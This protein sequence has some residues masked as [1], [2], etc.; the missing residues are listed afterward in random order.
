MVPNTPIENR[1]PVWKCAVCGSTEDLVEVHVCVGISGFNFDFC[2]TCEQTR[3]NECNKVL[4]DFLDKISKER[5]TRRAESGIPE[6]EIPKP[7]P[8]ENRWW[9]KFYKL[10]GW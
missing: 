10:I 5:A 7:D 1:W 8:Q 4:S 2:T 9:R 6:Q 3:S